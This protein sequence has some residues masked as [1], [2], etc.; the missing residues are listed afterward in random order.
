MNPEPRLNKLPFIVADAVCLL[1]AALIGLYAKSPFAP[2]P[3]VLCVSLVVVG[4]VALLIPFLV[5]YA[6]DS[7]EASARLR[8]ELEVQ[9]KRVQAAAESLGRAAAQIKA[10]EEAVQKSARDAETL[11][12]RMQEKLAEFNQAL[13]A[14]ENDE[15]EALEQELEELR[16][17]SSDQ[18]KAV[19]DKI[20][21]AT[22]DWAALEI[23]TRR[24]LSTAQEAAGKLDDLLKGSLVQ[25]DS[26]IASLGTLLPAAGVSVLVEAAP[27]AAPEEPKASPPVEPA[28]DVSS[29]PWSGPPP[30]GAGEPAPAEAPKPKKPRPPR[31]PKP[32]DTLAAMSETPAAAEP[33]PVAVTAAVEDSPASV[34]PEASSSSDGATRLLATAYIGIGNKLFIRGDGPGLSWDKGVPM[35]FVSI[36]KWGW[37]THDAAGPVSVKLYKN[38]EMAALSGGLTIEPGRHTEITALF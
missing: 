19:A 6:A 25:L 31:K 35:Q 29:P 10:I 15:R 21:K 16:A 14:K 3:L 7:R 20:S 11:P 28:P 18:L 27:S 32:E 9:V 37:S 30:T 22:T 8:D 38:D 23:A 33:E 36:G 24:Q 2:L 26:R 13:A 4:G 1:A 12:Y 17:V 34:A 5:D